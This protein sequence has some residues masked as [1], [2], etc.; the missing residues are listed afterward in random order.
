MGIRQLS[1]WLLLPFLFSLSCDRNNPPDT[2]RTSATPRDSSAK[3]GADALPLGHALPY[4]SRL[5][6]RPSDTLAAFGIQKTKSLAL[7][8]AEIERLDQNGFVMSNRNHFATPARGYQAIWTADLPVYVTADAL[9]FAV[10]KSH[11]RVLAEVELRALMPELRSL[12]QTMRAALAKGAAAKWGRGT[13]ESIDEYLAVALTLLQGSAAIPVAG[14]KNS[15]VK[16]YVSAATSSSGPRTAQLFGTSWT[17]DFSLFKPRGHYTRTPELQQYFR[18]VT[19]LGRA[20]LV[21]LDVSDAHVE[22]VHR[23][24]LVAAFALAELLT[25]AA[26]DS[27][28]RIDATVQAFVGDPDGLTVAALEALVRALGSVRPNRLPSDRELIDALERYG[29]SAIASGLEFGD[30]GT[31]KPQPIAF[32]LLPR[33]YTI[34]SHV[35]S[36]LTYDRVGGG[37]I[38]RLMP[39]PLD[40]GY[41]VLDNDVA[42]SLLASE[43]SEF[44]YATDLMAAHSLVNQSPDYWRSSLYGLWLASLRA[45]SPTIGDVRDPKAAHLPSV[46]AT[47]PWARRLLNTQL[48]SWAE[49][50]HN[51]VLYVDESMTMGITCKFPDGYVEPYPEFFDRLVDYA[52]RGRGVVARLAEKTSD[53]GDA[54]SHFERLE[55]AAY[56]LG[57][58]ARHERQGQKLTPEELT[59][60]NDMVEL[61]VGGCGGTERWSGWYPRLFF[62]EA[63]VAEFNPPI[64]DV[65]TQPTD[66]NG[67][68]VGRVLHVG[69]A[70]PRLFVVTIDSNGPPRAFA[71]ITSAYFERVTSGFNRMTDEMWSGEVRSGSP[72]D[73]AWVHSLVT[74]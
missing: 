65:H 18:C 43:L 37:T 42:A 3:R 35:F 39:S 44:H 51:N 41:A 38:K 62:N 16:A 1:A 60:L 57:E 14:G 20:K 40:I 74:R 13:V 50:R 27:W 32:A 63:D 68:V 23:Q 46:V 24:A 61:R 66:E 12:L 11:D 69:T 64:T 52:R 17:E 36:R 53:L 25:G 59:Y 9:M 7:D 70:M 26:R 56:T 2:S 34:D 58:I 54:V 33:R 5:P 30:G 31:T 8:T 67:N 21:L 49:L 45:L 22:V 10:F 28:S 48:A 72:K 29:P 71:G 4:L 73:P 6:Y 15:V 19:W 55:E 47:E